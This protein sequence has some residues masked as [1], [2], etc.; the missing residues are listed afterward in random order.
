MSA[1]PHV[2]RPYVSGCRGFDFK[3]VA[4]NGISEVY[5]LD[6]LISVA[7][8]RDWRQ[9]GKFSLLFC[10]NVAAIGDIEGCGAKETVEFFFQHWELTALER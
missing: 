10:F 8:S 3:L 4:G 1:Q 2:V 9:L 6:D 7:G 5:V